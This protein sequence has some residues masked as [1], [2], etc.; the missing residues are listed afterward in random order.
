MLKLIDET[1]KGGAL[2][3]QEHRGILIRRRYEPQLSALED[4]V[5]FLHRFQ[6]ED[7][8]LA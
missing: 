7:P 4:L 2:E 6:M 8:C 5:E 3:A 1:Q